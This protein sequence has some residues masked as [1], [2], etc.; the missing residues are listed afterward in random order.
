VNVIV[1][2][3]MKSV[4]C[5]KRLHKTK[6]TFLSGILCSRTGIKAGLQK[7]FFFFKKKAQ[8]GGFV[9]GFLVRPS[10]VKRPN[11]GS[12]GSGKTEKVREF[13][14]SGKIFFLEKLGKMKNWCHQ[15]SG[16][17]AKMHQ[18]SFPLGLCSRPH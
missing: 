11:Q 10:F 12:Y 5:A 7:T 15:M 1:K 4:R 3:F 13:E 8:Q 17:Q 14:W 9:M 2:E 6:M 18:I 16:F